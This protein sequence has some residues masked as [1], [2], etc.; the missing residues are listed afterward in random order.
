M[1]S[2]Q[3][4]ITHIQTSG[5]LTMVI[6]TI[7][8]NVSIKAVLIDTPKTAPYLVL[9]REVTLMFKETEVILAT[10]VGVLSIDNDINGR[11]K[12][13]ENGELLSRICLSSSIGEIVAVISVDASRKLELT[14]GKEATAMIKLNEV[15]LSP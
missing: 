8:E 7:K 4:A 12:A 11:V 14:V 10:N 6:V 15:I 13:I 5:N 2:F 1:N 9:G 3:G